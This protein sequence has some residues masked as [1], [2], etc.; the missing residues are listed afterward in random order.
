MLFFKN[1]IVE[2]SR[3][4]LED[5]C[6]VVLKGIFPNKL[7]DPSSFSILYSLGNIHVEK[8]LVDLGANLNMISYEPFEKLNLG[9][10]LTYDRLNR[11]CFS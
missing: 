9:K 2:M 7:K 10:P 4:E 3:I 8:A 11:K 6:P 1:N 5:A